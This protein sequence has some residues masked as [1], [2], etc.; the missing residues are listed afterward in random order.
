M[1]AFIK[2]NNFV[3]RL[4][5]GEFQFHAAGHTIKVYL[6]NVAPDAAADDVKADLAEI[7][8]GNG[9]VAGGV[10]IQNDLTEASGTA[11]VTAVDVTITASAGSIGPFQYAVTYDDTHANDA[12]VGAW[13]YG[14]A[15]TLADGESFTIDF[16]ANSLFTLA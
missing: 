15:L 14:S 10:D 2:F 9:Y 7:S 12:L 3:E 6:T 11:T 8:A 1:A 5:K 13:D 4:L 16:G